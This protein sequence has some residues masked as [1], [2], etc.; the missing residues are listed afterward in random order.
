[1]C[2]S[3]HSLSVHSTKGTTVDMSD[4]YANDSFTVIS[5]DNIDFLH[6][7]ARVVRGNGNSS[8][9]GTTIQL[10]QPLPSFS[11]F[12]PS[13]PANE[14]SLGMPLYYTAIPER[15]FQMRATACRKRTERSSPLPFPMKT[16]R[17]PKPKQKR[18]MRTG[19]EQNSVVQSDVASIDL[20]TIKLS[21]IYHNAMSLPPR[22]TANRFHDMHRRGSCS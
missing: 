18:R 5:A 9:H 3:R 7:H 10:V 14:G 2:I 6:K 17:F 8:W 1:M 19:S 20:H 16:T 15:G 11:L 21:T 4:L 13:S 12:G 22:Q